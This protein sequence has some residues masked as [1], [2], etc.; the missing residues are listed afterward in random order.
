MDEVAGFEQEEVFDQ[1][2][3]DHGARASLDTYGDVR[4]LQYAHRLDGVSIVP[5]RY[6]ST[7]AYLPNSMDTHHFEFVKPVE[8]SAGGAWKAMWASPH[9]EPTILMTWVTVSSTWG[10]FSAQGV[11]ILAAPMAG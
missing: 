3:L 2:C 8:D 11:P 7:V 9:A 6:H 5:N 10:V 4:A 1:R